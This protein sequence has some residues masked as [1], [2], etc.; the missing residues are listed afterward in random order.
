[1]TPILGEIAGWE[2]LL[3]LLLIALLFGSSKLPQLAR[4][5][6]QAS[7]EFRKGVAE[8]AAP[9]DEAQDEHH[10]TEEHNTP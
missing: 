1:M 7:K 4:S 5:L 6:G 8:G 3:V 9:D 10:N 2:G